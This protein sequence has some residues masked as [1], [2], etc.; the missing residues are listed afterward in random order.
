MSVPRRRLLR[1][2]SPS[3]AIPS[4][5]PRT[6]QDRR[7][8]AQLAR[9]RLNLSRWMARLKRAFHAVE[10]HQGRIGRLERLL[11]RSGES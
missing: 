3:E 11:S 4:R 9:E 1:P 7:R 2:A 6:H 8:E 5:T 10:K